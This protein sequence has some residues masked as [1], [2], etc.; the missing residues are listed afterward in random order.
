MELKV[1]KDFRDKYTK[2]IHVKDDVLNLTDERGV[3]LLKSP[4]VVVV[5]ETAKQEK[6]DKLNKTQN[7]AEK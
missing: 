5:K 4:Y 2:E 6:T 3:E 1:I 7:K